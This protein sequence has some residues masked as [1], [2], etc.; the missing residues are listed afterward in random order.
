MVT[1]GIVNAPSSKN[2]NI[3]PYGLG[4]SGI[5]LSLFR[6][7]ISLTGVSGGDYM[8]SGWVYS[9]LFY[10]FLGKRGGDYMV[11]ILVFAS[12]FYLLRG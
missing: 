2:L 5:R 6:A 3:Y 11:S 8:V 4:L 12:K 1:A 10:P 9:E 7:V